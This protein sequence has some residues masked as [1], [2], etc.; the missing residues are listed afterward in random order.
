MF[1]VTEN[2]WHLWQHLS[3]CI[4]V[5][6]HDPFKL[7]SCISL[8]SLSLSLS[9]SFPPL[10]PPHP[11]ALCDSDLLSLCSD[12]S[13]LHTSK[14][15]WS[16]CHLLR[17]ASWARRGWARSPCVRRASV[18][19]SSSPSTSSSARAPPGESC[20]CSRW[21]QVRHQAESSHPNSR[22]LVAAIKHYITVKQSFSPT[23]FTVSILDS[24]FSLG[25][26]ELRPHVTVKSNKIV[27]PSLWQDSHWM[28][29][30][31]SGV[32]G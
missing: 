31:Y 13:L 23:M 27:I 6:L 15:L 22:H 2:N 4:S 9:L 12:P 7:S 29:A 26:Q 19:A 30:N 10:L 18:S 16:S 32:C 1:Y 5:S 20:T 8:S 24:T 21:G 3:L 17:K 14:A 25:A 28:R 11:V